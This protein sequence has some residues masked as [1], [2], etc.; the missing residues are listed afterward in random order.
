MDGDHYSI[1]AGGQRI[2]ILGGTFDPVHNGHLAAA[3]AMLA[4]FSLDRLLLVPAVQSPH[5]QEY[6]VTGFAHRAA[7]LE[8][9]APFIANA[10]VSRVESERPPPSYSI[11]TL[12]QLRQQLGDAPA[13]YFATGLD[14]FMEIGLWKEYD[15]LPRL[16]NLVVVNRATHEMTGMRQV[17]AR[18][19]PRFAYDPARQAWFHRQGEG[20][21]YPLNMVPVAASSTLIRQRVGEGLSISHLVLPPVATY[22]AEHGLYRPDSSGNR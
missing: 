16:A 8:L 5:K 21:V 9:V 10:V 13:L 14:A 17:M 4:R 7:M 18:Y 22:I 19:F 15:R 6:T 3:Q 1:A 2:G 12:R 20:A 11:D